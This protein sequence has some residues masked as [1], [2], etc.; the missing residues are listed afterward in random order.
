M[1]TG[2]ARQIEVEQLASRC[3]LGQHSGLPC[4]SCADFTQ[5][6]AFSLSVEPDGS[7]KGLCHRASCGFR[8]NGSI[9]AISGA[10]GG[11]Y[12]P[13]GSERSPLLG[14]RERLP[15]P[16]LGVFE[17]LT[18]DDEQFF[19]NRFVLCKKDYAGMR[20]SEGHYMVPIVGPTGLTRGWIRRRPWAGSPLDLGLAPQLA[21]SLTYM[22]ND[23]PVLSWYS[24][25]NV[26]S[27]ATILVEDQISAMRIARDVPLRAVA[28]LGVG[29]N[30]E[31]VAEIQRH[32]RHVIIALDS[33]AT[34]Q[35]FAMARKW[36]Q[37]FHSCRVVILDKDIKDCAI[38]TVQALFQP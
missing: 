22:N 24:N 13:T 37:A 28:L 32:E 18:A 5:D 17:P 2:L 26:L 9:A 6:R 30:E 29:L 38:Q 10:E 33:D 15:R 8:Y 7:I 36:G 23:E 31:K 3:G 11:R 35:A 16:Y 4:P 34:G 25:Y 14:Q 19:S 20:R 21:K 1:A 12:L 27:E